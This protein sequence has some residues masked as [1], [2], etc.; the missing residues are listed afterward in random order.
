MKTSPHLPKFLQAETALRVVQLATGAIAIGLIFW[1]LQF[2]TR[3]IC[4]GDYDGYYHIKW[5]WML[6]EA[7]RNHTFPPRFLWLP[8]TSL[9][10]TQYV[11][12]HLLFH[13]FQ[14][15]FTWFGNLR[16]GAKISAVVFASLALFSCY[17]LLVRYR[18]RYSLI[19]LLALLACSAPF[20]YRL[21]MSKAPPFAIIY[22]VIGIH[23]LFKKKYWPLLPLSFLFT[24]TYDM[25]VMLLLSAFIW[26][27]VIGWTERRFEWRPLVWVLLGTTA[28]FV[29]NP[30]FPTN[31]HLFY[32]HLKIKI[33][34]KEFNTKVGQEWY[35]YE[36]WEF[37][38]NSIVACVAMVVG[39]IA[40]DPS[41]RK[42]SQHS[43]FMLVLATVLMLMA[44]RW[45]RIAEYWPPFAVIF[46]AFAL[47]HWLEGTRS[48]FTRL[49][50]DI[51]DELQPFLDR[52]H[53]VATES[54]DD[55]R[56]IWR[57]IG[58]ATITIALGM[59]LA[60]NLYVTFKDIGESK[61][62]DFYRAGLQW[63]R[64]NIPHQQIV[65]NTDWDDF[66][67]LFYYDPDHVYVS[68]LDPSYL[69]DKD[70]K[71][72]ELYVNI[73]LGKEEDPGPLIRDRFGAR[74]IFTDNEHDDFSDNAR[75][76]GWFEIIYEDTECTILHIR[77]Q[78]VEPPPEDPVLDG[79]DTDLFQPTK[80]A[81]EN[82][83]N[84]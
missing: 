39:Y 66:P 74:Y 3:A 28:G 9:N 80:P 64:A 83:V 58:L 23:L 36:T 5:S 10:P 67:R 8:L 50:T 61:G 42:R 12:H 72:S 27:A 19:W 53:T 14:M 52:P 60:V 65:F 24:L 40:F 22:L 4:C 49:S 78:K 79:A 37:L 20:L 71:L 32:E 44:A 38:S 56:A 68:G 29:I 11:D 76:S 81:N 41:D 54:D 55:M 2:S 26:T 7:L 48:H 63:M 17:W 47:Q 51:L 70:P 82:P 46:C 1:Q 59:A 45:R 21:N 57:T 35:P 18:I 73:T 43:L 31:L 13:F 30:Y 6:G 84:K 33:T 34:P 25:F 16:L 75:E 69:Y 77:D 15:P 62:D